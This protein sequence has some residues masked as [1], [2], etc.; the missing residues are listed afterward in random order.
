MQFSVNKT[1][2]SW[3][4]WAKVYRS[5]WGL[6]SSTQ[7]PNAFLQIS[8][9]SDSTEYISIDMLELQYQLEPKADEWYAWTDNTHEFFSIPSAAECRPVCV[10][11]ERYPVNLELTAPGVETQPCHGLVGAALEQGKAPE[12]L[13]FIDNITA[14][15]N[16]AEVF[17]KGKKI[18][19]IHLKIGFSIKWSMVMGPAQEV[20]KNK[21]VR[22]MLSDPQGCDQ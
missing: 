6:C 18:I 14:W 5:Q 22:H 7:E 10:Y 4:Q 11:L 9:C 12:H 19:Q 1:D 21:M 2:T 15:E 13:Q 17:E 8:D 16:T 3:D 20:L